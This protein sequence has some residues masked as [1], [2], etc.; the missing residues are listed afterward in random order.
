MLAPGAY[1]ASTEAEVSGSAQAP[2]SPPISTRR[3]TALAAIE[4]YNSK[5]NLE[6]MI[7]WRAPDC[8]H[9]ILPTSLKV[10]AMDNKSYDA[11]FA[12]NLTVFSNFRV[13]VNDVMED[14]A[15]NKVVVWAHS[16]A[17]TAIGPYANEYMLIFHFTPAGD[18][19]TRFLE[20]VDS[21]AAVAFFPRLRLYLEKRAADEAAGVVDHGAAS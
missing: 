3:K 5:W 19:V 8:I 10:P 9:E 20:W 2:S 18:K 14:A 6:N 11:Y 7:A 21:A 4:S 1:P 16:T 17:D 15:A 13:T 12:T